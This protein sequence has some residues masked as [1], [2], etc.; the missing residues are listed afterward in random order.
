MRQPI[1][2]YIGNQEVDF[3][4][5][6]DILYTYQEDDL[7]NPTV[8]KNSFTKT[9]EIEG[10]PANN[11]LFGH[12]WNVERLQGSDGSGVSFNA[13]KKAPFTLYLDH[14]IYESGYVKLDNVSTNGFSTKYSITLYGGLGDF[15]YNLSINDD[16]NELKLKDLDFGG[17]QD[18]FNFTIN[19]ETVKEAWDTLNDYHPNRPITKWD[20][21]NFMP[22]Y[23]GTPDDFD[24]NKILINTKDT[25]LATAAMNDGKY[26]GTKDGFVLA[27]LPD[28]MTEWETRDLRSYLQ[29]PCIRM[30]EIIK[31]CCN[32]NN[33]GGY[34]VVLDEDFFNER[35]P[36]YEDTWVT[37]P[38]IQALEYSS[39]EQILDGATL[40][41]GATSG[42]V[43][44]YMYIPLSFDLGEF[45]Q[46]APSSINIG[47]KIKV[48][49]SYFKYS[50]WMRFMGPNT[51]NLAWGDNSE[52][53]SLFV[54]AI[55]LNGDQVIA[56][57][58]T[59]NLTSPIRHNGKLYYGNNSRYDDGHK[60]TSFLNKPIYD[61]L[62]TFNPSGFT[63]ENAS[64]PSTINFHISGIN[65][66]VT[67]LKLVYY[68]GA[69]KEKIK[70]SA[71]AALFSEPYYNYK[72]LEPLSKGWTTL[73]NV[74]TYTAGDFTSDIKAVI[75]ESIGRTGTQVSK[76]LLLGSEGSPCDYLLSFTKMFGLYYTKDIESNTIYIQTRKTFYHR[77]EIMDLSEYIDRSKELN[78]TPLTFDTKWYEFI[79]EMDETQ[80]SRN[81]N[82]KRGVEF[83]CKIVNTGY[84]FSAE[85]KN[86]LE[87]NIIKSGIEGLEKSKYFTCYT[88]DFKARPWFGYGLR[89]NLYNGEDTYEM[90]ASTRSMGNVLQLNE[91][92]QMKYYD[93]FPKLQFHDEKNG[94]TDG[95]NVLVFFNGF[96]NVNEGRTNKLSYILSDDS[97]WQTQLNEGTPCWLFTANETVSG[98]RIA[99]T[100]NDIPVFERYKTEKN[101]D[102]VSHSL[103]FGASQDLYVPTYAITD[104]VN[105]YANFWKS[106]L[107]DLY[108]VN[109]RIL[110]CHVRLDG[111]PSIYWLRRFYWFNNTIWR[112]SRIIDWNVSSYDTTEVEFVKVQ[113]LNN[114]TSISQGYINKITL[115]SD[116]YEL[117]KSGGTITLRVT[118]ENGGSWSI[119]CPESNISIER[120]SGTG[121]G[122]FFATINPNTDTYYK[123]FH[124]T[125]VRNDNGQQSKITIMQNY[126]NSTNVEIGD[127]KKAII[128]DYKGGEIEYKFEWDNQENERY[129][130]EY[131]TRGDV[132]FDNVDIVS[133][134]E[135]N[136]AIVSVS[137]SPRPTISSTE[138]TYTSRPTASSVETTNVE[139]T[140]Y[141]D[142]LPQYL[143]FPKDGGTNQLEFQYVKDVEFTS[144]P[145]WISNIENKGDGLY[146]FTAIPNYYETAREDEITAINVGDRTNVATFTAR[147]TEGELPSKP[148]K[149]I[150]VY[151]DNLYFEASGGQQFIN[152]NLDNPWTSEKNGDFF[153]TSTNR[154]DGSAIL[155]VTTNPNIGDTLQGSLTITDSVTGDEYLV[156]I[157]QRGDSPIIGFDVAPNVTNVPASG[158]NYA[159]TITYPDRFGDIVRITSPL[160][161]TN[162]VWRGNNGTVIFTVP[163]NTL[164]TPVT[165]DA[166]FTC[167]AGSETIHFVQDAFVEEG[168]VGITEMVYDYLPSTKPNTV[169][170]NVP[171]YA[172]TSD[173][174]ISVDP[175]EGEKGSE[176]IYI[177]LEENKGDAR[178]GYVYIRSK[179]T[180]E[181]LAQIKVTQGA[182]EEIL[183]VIP[184]S[185]TFD[186]EGGTATF[187]IHSNVDWT[188]TL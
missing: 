169:T 149:L 112:I 47:A 12:F 18:E 9:I 92:Y 120:Y 124:I 33:N 170:S 93:I 28:E 175:S 126:T 140:V 152:V 38:M 113:D 157:S 10:T 11:S 176:N 161:H 147:Q 133:R 87:D 141:I 135:A 27:D 171:W 155:S 82:L 104:D 163:E 117:P 54:Q 101:S 66:N 14:D 71:L 76:S 23:N 114:Y 37:L 53:G 178:E 20:K 5:P 116:K 6:P 138:I 90:T 144:V 145:F 127:R 136:A 168:S 134:R 131:A 35:N 13:S 172:V 26:Y 154:G 186:A 31:A 125:A 85:K 148:E 63:R 184:E 2:L 173:N 109:N 56:A 103:D 36:Y 182:F 183:E 29:R 60:Y 166:T 159:A 188:I 107:E 19:K 187:R 42:S 84:E 151:P 59:Y 30:K 98:K 165:F 119:L 105:I 32:Q 43:D 25:S 72:L 50:S 89:Y 78:M 49:N 34:N 74:N 180:N 129:V 88:N 143:D 121:N 73:S 132:T 102:K 156:T 130:D 106:Y 21:I 3:P 185:L 22:A 86:L 179:N 17:G 15:F 100:L 142:Q 94:T 69:N 160:K 164:T 167:E 4:S 55:A 68:W 99:I 177:T 44:S 41:A 46:N 181:L 79:Q 110:K 153:V 80:F 96:K 118:P 39:E 111:K 174:W 139:T 58:E 95:N 122:T 81:Y 16:G 8:V 67:S 97:A 115:V 77:D 24:A 75:G 45:S 48:G 158:G 1:H 52:F 108:D 7:T 70:K 91:N 162:I 51:D 57:S 62:G 65:Q 128:V 61:V 150:G 64:S 123:Y 137:R 83:G 146:V 40:I